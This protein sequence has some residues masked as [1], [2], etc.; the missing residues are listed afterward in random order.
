MSSSYSLIIS[1]QFARDTAKGRSGDSD[2]LNF[3]KML[4]PW[5]SEPTDDSS[6]AVLDQAPE[7][8]ETTSLL[9]L[10]NELF[11]RL[12][13]DKKPTANTN[14]FNSYGCPTTSLFSFK[15]DPNSHCWQTPG[16]P[17]PIN[18]T[19]NRCANLISGLAY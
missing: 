9:S 7:D 4:D 8:T 12:I 18:R 17:V 16:L 1:A 5:L 13:T 6:T 15:E 14:G 3:W 11:S 19:F 10:L 2:C